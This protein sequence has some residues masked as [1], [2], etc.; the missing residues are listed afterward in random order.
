MR[1]KRSVSREGS[2][3]PVPLQEAIQHL[4]EGIGFPAGVEELRILACWDEVVGEQVS[5]RAKPDGLKGGRLYVIVEDP[6][7]LHQ[8][9]LL[10]PAL[11]ASLNERLG[12][13]VVKELYLKVGKL[14]S[15]SKKDSPA[16]SPDPSIEV[17]TL[18]ALLAQTRDLPCGQVLRRLLARVLTDEKKRHLVVS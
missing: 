13:P 2:K 17:E 11:I 12:F 9:S 8:L 4:L 14:P 10:K 5:R 6:V 3:G 1:R 15:A 16:L 18:D 7:W